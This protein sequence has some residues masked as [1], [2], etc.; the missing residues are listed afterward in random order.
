M[1]MQD[2]D[3]YRTKDR[4]EIYTLRASNCII[5]GY[6]PDERGAIAFR[7]VDRG[8]CENILADLLS[9]KLYVYMHDVINAMRDAQAVFKRS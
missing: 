2:N 8:K 1:N 3:F 5:D 7:F 6:D 9:K 4:Y